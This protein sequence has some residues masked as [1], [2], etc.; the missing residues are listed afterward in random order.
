MKILTFQARRFWWK[1]FSRTLDSASDDVVEDEVSEALVAFLHIEQ[2]DEGDARRRVL[3]QTFKH[4]KWI[5]NKRSMRAVVLH[6]FTHLGGASAQPQFARQMLD[7]LA[8]RLH[9]AGYAVKLTP[10]GW[11]CEWSLDV[12]G[13]SMA[14]VFKEIG[15]SG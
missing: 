2:C 5:A 6:S 1:S 14:K 11:L 7:D 15:P 9:A 8:D 4:L 12:F 13:E 3:Q 10:F